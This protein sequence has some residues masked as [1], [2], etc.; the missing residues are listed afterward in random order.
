MVGWVILGGWGWG[1]KVGGLVKY[2]F[3]SNMF[4][5]LKSCFKVL[6]RTMFLQIVF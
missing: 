6:A 2:L 5:C 4:T 3:I 1:V